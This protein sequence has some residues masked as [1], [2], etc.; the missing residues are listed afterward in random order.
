M[1]G[2]GVEV[3]IDVCGL[4]AHFV[5]QRAIPSPVKIQVQE[6]Q[7]AFTFGFHGEL[8]RLMDAVQVV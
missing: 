8:N 7:M 2:L 6:R 3:G 4:A 1:K 5:S